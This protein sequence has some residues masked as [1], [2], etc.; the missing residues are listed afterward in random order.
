M[1]SFLA[2]CSI[3]TSPK[4]QGA[5]LQ[6]RL[7]READANAGRRMCRK[8]AARVAAVRFASPTV[9][10]LR[11]QH[12]RQACMAECDPKHKRN[13]TGHQPALRAAADRPA[14]HSLTGRARSLP[15]RWLPSGAHAVVVEGARAVLVAPTEAAALGLAAGTAVPVIDGERRRR[16]RAWRRTDAEVDVEVVGSTEVEVVGVTEAKVA[17]GAGRGAADGSGAKRSK[18]F[19]S[20]IMHPRSIP[21]TTPLNSFRRLERKDGSLSNGGLL[22]FT[23]RR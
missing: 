4:S 22:A 20:L 19:S 6:Q 12:I 18:R 5:C 7:A 17:A 11:K 10:D 1:L 23:H 9:T 14:S 13:T 16:D 3:S 8:R 15:W 2:S 21:Q